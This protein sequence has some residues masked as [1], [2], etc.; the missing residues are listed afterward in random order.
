M[1]YQASNPIVSADRQ[2]DLTARITVKFL[3]TALLII[4]VCA[5][6]IANSFAAEQD[7]QSQNQDTQKE[8]NMSETSTVLLTTSLGDITLEV[9]HK[10]APATAKNFISYVE[11]GFYDGVIFHRVIRGFMIQTGGH[12]IGMGRKA[13]NAAIINESDNGLD[14][15]KYTISMARTQDP[16][17]AT[18]QFFINTNDNSNLNYNKDVPPGWGY[19]VFGKVIE[20]TDVVDEIEKVQTTRVGPHADVP[21]TDVVIVSAKVL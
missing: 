7:A 10:N 14:N 9:D 1:F 6:T 8:S 5:M 18:S 20:G 15:D 16:H 19:A 4:S 17:S 11:S 12:E 2:L 13:P 21:A 3:K